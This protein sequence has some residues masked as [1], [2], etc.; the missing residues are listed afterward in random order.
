MRIEK[1]YT[2]IDVTSK[3]EKYLI[4]RI[5][6]LG[7]LLKRFEGAR[8]VVAFVELARSAKHQKGN[9]YY[10]EINLKLNGRLLRAEHN[11]PDIRIAIDNA[12]N[13]LRG[14]IIKYKDKIISVKKHGR[15]RK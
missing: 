13:K 4:K 14:E 1:K 5:S 6:S 2:Q 3:D 7:N 12:K 15:P 10:A 8:E 9:V 11:D